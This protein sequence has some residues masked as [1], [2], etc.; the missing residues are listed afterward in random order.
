MVSSYK[1]ITLKFNG[2]VIQ[3]LLQFVYKTCHAPAALTGCWSI[4]LRLR[5]FKFDF[6]SSLLLTFVA[7]LPLKP[8][9]NSPAAFRMV[10]IILPGSKK[11]PEPPEILEGPHQKKQKMDNSIKIECRKILRTLMTHKFGPIFN[12]PV[13]PVELGIPDYFTIISQPMDFGTISK[14][15]ED[16]TYSFAEAFA[17]DI[18]LTFSNAMRYNPPENVVHLM[19]KELNNLFDRS[20]KSLEAKLIK[21][22]K[23]VPKQGKLKKNVLDTSK[24]VNSLPTNTL[25]SKTVKKPVASVGL[26]VKKP[27]DTSNATTC[28]EVKPSVSCEEKMRLKKELMVALKGDLSG[29]LRGFLRKYGLISSNKEKIESVFSLFGDGTLLEL[30]RV[31]KGCFSTNM[32]KGDNDHVK[33]QQ[34][35]ET[36]ERQ[37]LEVKSNIESRIRAARAAKEALLESA[38]SD[39]QMRRDRERERVEKMKRTVIMDDNLAVLMELEKLCQYSGFKNPLEKIGLRLK[40]EHYY[41]YEYIDD[42]DGVISDELEDGE[43]F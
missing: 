13:D 26:K 7:T 20:W 32:G 33:T 4:F 22:S 24:K 31:M 5:S 41:G 38:K 40:E 2:I 37:K 16:N 35:K 9:N 8:E 23:T 34:T 25:E 3:V 27:E 10:K 29:P 18:R 14:K 21:S 17:A 42:D 1:N 28:S 43:I 36:M 15:L 6:L 12:Q 39:L 19:A 30:G 11:R